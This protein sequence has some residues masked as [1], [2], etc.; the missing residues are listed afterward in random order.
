[1]AGGR[2]QGRGVAPPLTSEPA[3]PLSSL[4]DIEAAEAS[5]GAH[6]SSALHCCT[7]DTCQHKEHLVTWILFNNYKITRVKIQSIC[8]M[9]FLI[10]RLQKTC[11]VF[12]GVTRNKH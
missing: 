9:Y 4:P 2:S 11:V 8:I 6:E 1:M 5:A 10:E 7:S 12:P 3:T